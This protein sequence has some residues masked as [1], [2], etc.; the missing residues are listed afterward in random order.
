MAVLAAAMEAQ[1]LSVWWDSNIDGGVEFSRVIEREL[2]EAKN[3]VVAWSEA[4]VDSHWVRDEAE[5]ARQAQKLLPIT[6]DGIPPPMGFRQIHAID[7]SEWEGAEDAAPL[8]MLLHSL[9]DEKTP[10]SPVAS[11]IPAPAPLHDPRSK[12]PSIAVLPFAVMSADPE[13]EFLVDGLTEDLITALSTN[14][15][16]AVAARTSVFAYKDKSV[17]IRDVGRALNVR[18]V[19]E[20][21]VRAMGERARVSAQFIEAESGA[22]IWAN[23]YDLE[24]KEFTAAPDEVVEK[25]TASIGAQLIWAE[26]DRAERTDEF[27]LGSWELIQKASAAIGRSAGSRA[28]MLECVAQ[29]N[30]AIELE[31]DSGLAH[32]LLSWFYNAAITNSVFVDDEFPTFLE[33]AK[34]HLRIA[35]DL[36]GNDYLCLMW[37]GATESYGGMNEQSLKTLRKV[38]DRN[39]ANAE[40]WF[41]ISQ[42]YAFMGRYDEAR[43]AITRATELAPEAGFGLQHGWYRGVVEYLAGNYEEA[44]PLVLNQVVNFPEYGIANSCAALLSAIAGD[45]ESAH[46]YMRRLKKHNPQMTVKRLALLI[47]NQKDQEKA[48]REHTLMQKIWDD[49]GEPGESD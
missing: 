30:R 32:A 13:M 48:K 26:A 16:L 25:I 44:L 41:H 11:G 2:K 5:Y 10:P 49:A 43:Q 39:P 17:D 19:V 23:K 18:Y 3:V 29:L 45:E 35:R 8:Q 46:K 12:K 47:L 27:D 9:G 21:S 31:P 7:F 14:R 33:N 37:I 36:V 4:S 15:H 28:T 6:L 24:L 20:G 40:A 22:H 38:L 34:K 42:T 1:G